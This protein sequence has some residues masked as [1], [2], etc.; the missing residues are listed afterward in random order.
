MITTSGPTAAQLAP[1]GRV[2]VISDECRRR[3]RA[4]SV[5]VSPLRVNLTGNALPVDLTVVEVLRHPT[6]QP[7][8]A[9]VV[10]T[11]QEATVVNLN[12]PSPEDPSDI[13]WVDPVHRA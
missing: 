1:P 12:I 8:E 2:V 4:R 10:R 3:R 7:V 5:L 9:V 13:K 11:G 6:C